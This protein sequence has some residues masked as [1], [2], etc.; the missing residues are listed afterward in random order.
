MPYF[1]V[2]DVEA[3]VARAVELGGTLLRP[4]AGGAAYLRDPAGIV[5]ALYQVPTS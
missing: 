2:P 3:A 4:I 1:S 5:S